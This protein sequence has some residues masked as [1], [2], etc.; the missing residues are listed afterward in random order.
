MVSKEEYNNRINEIQSQI[1]KLRERQQ[2]DYH[3]QVVK[4]KAHEITTIRGQRGCRGGGTDCLEWIDSSIRIYNEKAKSYQA[5]IAA[6]EIEL[7][8]YIKSVREEEKQKQIDDIKKAIAEQFR[9]EEKRIAD[10]LELKRKAQVEKIVNEH[11]IE[12]PKIQQAAMTFTPPVS[13]VPVLIGVVSLLVL[14]RGK[15]L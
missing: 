13:L 11:K 15:K 6:K 7:D 12:K 1:T 8:N 14:S 3:Q 10:E 5:S 9:A 2:A 4:K